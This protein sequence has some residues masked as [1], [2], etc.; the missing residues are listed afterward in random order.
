MPSTPLET[1]DAPSKSQRKREMQ[2]LQDLGVEL[3][4]L[5]AA[6]LATLDLPEP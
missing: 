5:P 1:D 3:A 4:A 6:R 2:A